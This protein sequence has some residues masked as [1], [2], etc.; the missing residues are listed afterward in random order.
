MPL[1][2]PGGAVL[3]EKLRV[4]ADPRVCVDICSAMEKGSE[5]RL[6]MMKLLFELVQVFLQINIFLYTYTST[7]KACY[8][9]SS[10]AR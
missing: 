5:E 1:G 2:M 8:I 10:L 7:Y 6:N 3:S 4:R 9:D